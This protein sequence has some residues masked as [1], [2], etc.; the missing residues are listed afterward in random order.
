MKLFKKQE[1]IS[2]Y[3][4]NNKN[5]HL[6]L[7]Q[8]DINR[9]GT[10]VFHV[11]EPNKLFKK[12]EMNNVF[13]RGSHYYEFWTENTKLKFSYD[14]DINLELNQK[15][16]D[17]NL[18]NELLIELITKTLEG[19]KKYFN[20]ELKPTDIIVLENEP[21]LQ[22]IESPN[23]KS[24]HIIFNKLCFENYTLLKLLYGKLEKD[25]NISSYF[26]DSKIYGMGCLRMY[27][28]SKYGKNT[29]LVMT[30]YSTLGIPT[31]KVGHC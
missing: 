28:N 3:K 8:E 17:D 27:F 13:N 9:A 7:F 14:I 25:Y 29:I 22:K 20:Y 5:D 19:I 30:T 6:M 21:E 16:K 18:V 12:I 31:G 23:K 2:Y 15:Y 24:Y 10:K 11:M 26:T 1:A 4:K